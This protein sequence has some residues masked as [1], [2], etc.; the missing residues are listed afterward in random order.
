[1]THYQKLATLLFRSVAVLLMLVGLVAGLL[2]LLISMISPIG[3]A[4]VAFALFY[5]LPTMVLGIALFSLSRILAR[6]VCND[7]DTF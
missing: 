3:I 7:F 4:G 1:M 6:F 5:S 2:G